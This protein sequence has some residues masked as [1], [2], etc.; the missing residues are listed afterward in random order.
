MHITIIRFQRTIPKSDLLF[1]LGD[2]LSSDHHTLYFASALVNLK[3]LGI[4]H[5]LLDRVL[6][7]EAGSAE[8]LHGLG[9]VPV[10]HVGRVSLGD[11]RK[12]G[13][14]SALIWCVNGED[15]Q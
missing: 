13:V 14:S 8:D 11:R 2:M 4:S 1:V 5:Q 3:D 7:V 15:D 9:G 6:A 12:V 10:G